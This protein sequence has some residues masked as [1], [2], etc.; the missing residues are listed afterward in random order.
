MNLENKTE[1]EEQG[2]KFALIDC[3]YLPQCFEDSGLDYPCPSSNKNDCHLLSH[4]KKKQESQ[5]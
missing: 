5:N 1:T 3:K 4:Y 2:R